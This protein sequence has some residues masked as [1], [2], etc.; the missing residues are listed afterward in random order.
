MDGKDI[1]AVENPISAVFDLAEDV[2]HQAPKMR[3]MMKYATVFVSIWLFLDFMLIMTISP[4]SFPLMVILFV[5]LFSLRWVASNTSRF[6]LLVFAAVDAVFIVLL[7]GQNLIIGIL[8][9]GLFVLGVILLNLISELNN[10][11]E[12]YVLRH[13]AIKSVREEDPVVYIPEGKSSVDRLL[14]YLSS[15]NPQLRESQRKADFIQK[16]AILKGDSG[17]LYSFDCYVQS[18]PSA[19]W[20]LFGT[21]NA[22][23]ALYMKNFEDRPE[24]KDLI[25]LKKAVED[26]SNESRIPPSRVIA[27]WKLSK[28]ESIDD[29]VYG[30]L[31][32]EVIE[33]NPRGSAFNCSMELITEKPDDTYDFIPFVS[34]GVYR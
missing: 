30:F 17:I 9:T 1:R 33:F 7:F 32:G 15:K 23:Y 25:A 11:F 28:D 21:G 34:E 4:F 26:V 12:Y 20:K 24:L 2:N 16:P 14:H 31:T 29:D 18:S 13:R 27:L 22:G 8:L 19:L 3:K 5:L 10:F 6:A